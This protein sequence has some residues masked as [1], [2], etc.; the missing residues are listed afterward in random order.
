MTQ[1]NN[2]PRKKLQGHCHNCRHWYRL[3]PKNNKGYC[4]EIEKMVEANDNM[5]TT[6]NFYCPLHSY[7]ED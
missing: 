5:I 6:A 1:R 4:E 3:T 7:K 2:I